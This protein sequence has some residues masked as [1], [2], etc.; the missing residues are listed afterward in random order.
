M[1][2]LVDVRAGHS[3]AEWLRSQGYDVLEVRDRDK[4]MSDEAM[5]PPMRKKILSMS[6][7]KFIWLIEKGEATSVYQ[8]ACPKLEASG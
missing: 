4:K 6:S 3:L 1:K 5:L 7:R 2:F 8:K